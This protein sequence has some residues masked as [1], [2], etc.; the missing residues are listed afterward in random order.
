[1]ALLRLALQKSGRLSD[2][3][4]RLIEDCGI[5]FSNHG[6]SLKSSAE[7]FPLDLYFLRDDDIPGYV[8]DGVADCGIVGEN[9]LR[10]KQSDVRV[11]EPLGFGRCRLAIAVP[12]A[13]EY[14]SARDL[15][16]LDIATSYPVLLQSFLDA[17]NISARTHVISGSA[18]L[19]PGIGLADA[20]CDLVSTGSTLMS[21]GLKEVETVMESQAVLIARTDLDA[22][23]E[24]TLDQLRFRLESVGRAKRYKYILLNIPNESIE[25]VS[26]ILPGMKSPTVMPLAEEGWSSVHSVVHEDEFWEIVDKLKEAGAQGLLV[27]AVEKMVV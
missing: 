15:A 7:N 12:R 16:D 11:L 5:H 2:S 17:N 21:N 6:A 22:D 24:A 27:T 1:M 4:V 20:V 23:T 25:T 10:E 9:V 19:A 14:S 18:E 26:R 3:S 8:A 13:F